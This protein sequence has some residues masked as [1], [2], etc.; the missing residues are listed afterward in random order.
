VYP[1]EFMIYVESFMD[2]REILAYGFNPT[3][4]LYLALHNNN[5]ELAKKEDKIFV[6][7]LR[8]GATNFGLSTQHTTDTARPRG[9][10]HLMAKLLSQ[11]TN[12]ACVVAG[13]GIHK[14]LVHDENKMQVMFEGRMIYFTDTLAPMEFFALRGQNLVSIFERKYE[15]RHAVSYFAST[16]IVTYLCESMVLAQPQLIRHWEFV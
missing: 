5:Q 3:E 1:D 2:D 7:L 8:A 4:A 9:F 12:V 14:E 15:V 6:S 16:Q 10:A 11:A 13:M